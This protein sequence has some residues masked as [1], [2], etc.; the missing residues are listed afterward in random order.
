[1]IRALILNWRARRASHFLNQCRI[2]REREAIHS[3]ARQL[4]K[5]AGLPPH[6]AL[7]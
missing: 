7:R 1:M 2:R 3:V 4:R 5:E 6:P